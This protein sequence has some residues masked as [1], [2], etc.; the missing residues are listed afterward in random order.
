MTYRFPNPLSL[1]VVQLVLMVPV[2]FSFDKGTPLVF[3]CLGLVN[4]FWIARLDIRRFIRLVLPLSTL[5]FGL[6]FMNLL[7]PAEGIN[8]LERGITIF[9]R[10]FTLICLS[11]GY[12]LSISPYDLIRALMQNWHL[13]YRLGY[14]LFAGWNT[15][16]LLRRDIELAQ[17]AHE[18][19]YA[20]RNGTSRSLTRLP[21]TILSGAIL[22][23]ER[24]S[25][26]M[27]GR[28]L[29]KAKNRSFLY[30]LP[31]TMLDTWYCILTALLVVMLW[32]LL[33]LNG[34]FIF[35]LG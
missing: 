22:H 6:F 31:W 26:S 21:I 2:L 10:S 16:P 18:I 12:I 23:G 32:T 4:L 28:G 35:D 1:L 25:I 24:L 29:D 11:S 27:A 30:R 3:L 17:R 19:R 34:S 5:S 7:F 9:L 13:S 8:G 14:S 20:G 33:I 15:I